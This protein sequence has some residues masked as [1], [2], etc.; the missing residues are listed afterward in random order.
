MRR[1]QKKRVVRRKPLYKRKAFHGR[2]FRRNKFRSRINIRN[3]PPEV[4]STTS[5]SAD[6]ANFGT[7]VESDFGTVSSIYQ[8]HYLLNGLATGTSQNNR[9]A[10]VVRGVRVQADLSIHC[11]NSTS[12]DLNSRTEW[13]VIAMVLK[14]DDPDI[15]TAG[16][17]PTTTDYLA[18]PISSSS[19]DEAIRS[20]YS[21]YLKRNWGIL[22]DKVHT[23]KSFNGGWLTKKLSIPLNNVHR[24]SG[25]AITDGNRGR[26]FLAVI[27]GA[28]QGDGALSSNEY[29]VKVQSKYFYVDP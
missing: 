29:K 11:K 3:I 16:T 25:T 8:A 28:D 7:E 18:R 27:M 4:K 24:F 19:N 17:N 14:D 20:P 13:R 1:F 2:K 15:Y 9:V 21:Y 6:N 10:S 23:C 12:T 5:L 26:I 22:Y